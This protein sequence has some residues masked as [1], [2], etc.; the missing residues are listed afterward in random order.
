M[1]IDYIKHNNLFLKLNMT[2][3]HY[4]NNLYKAILSQILCTYIYI[5]ICMV[6]LTDTISMSKYNE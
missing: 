3:F 4:N 2:H 6:Y 1:S 5:Y